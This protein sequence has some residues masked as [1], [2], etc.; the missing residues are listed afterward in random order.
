MILLFTHTLT[1]IPQRVAEK[2]RGMKKNIS[3]V[4]IVTAEA[5]S[6]CLTFSNRYSCYEVVKYVYNMLSCLVKAL[7][8]VHNPSFNAILWR[9]RVDTFLS[10]TT[11]KACAKESGALILSV[12]NIS[13]EEPTEY[14]SSWW[15]SYSYSWFV[16]VMQIF[17]FRLRTEDYSSHV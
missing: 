6:I 8:E 15:I 3:F 17:L 9:R 10:W 13:A 1:C 5:S 2:A 4:S 7:I 11:S 12:S 16:I 14:I